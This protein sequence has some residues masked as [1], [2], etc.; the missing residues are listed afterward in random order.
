MHQIIFNRSRFDPFIDRST[1]LLRICQLAFA[2]G[3]LMLIGCNGEPAASPSPEQNGRPVRVIEAKALSG[4]ETFR[5]PAAL[6][7]SQRAHLAFLQPGYL[8]ERTVERGQDV[9]VGEVLATLHNPALQPGVAAAEAAVN[10][11]RSRLTQLEKDTARLEELVTRNLAS[12]DQLDQTRASRDGAQAALEQANARLDEAR[13]QLLDASLR[14]PFAGRIVEVM[15]EPGDFAAAGQPV[16]MIH[17]GNQLEIELQLPGR[18][19][20]RLEPG[21]SLD[22]MRFD[23]GALIGATVTE[24]GAAQPGQTATV[25]ARLKPDESLAWRPGDAV[26]AELDLPGVEALSVPLSSI[27][28]PGTRMSKIFRVRDQTAEEV[29]VE[30][31][32]T[33]RGWVQVNGS[34]EAGDP[35]VVAGQAQLLDGEP[36]RV[37][38]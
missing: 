6:R 37:I 11:A 8:A 38:D 36:V 28:N 3:V 30:T 1:S 23:D 12:Q 22:V 24:I 31:G 25:I 20:A 16:M 19:A 18:V 32:R 5:F 33:L 13:N 9:A 4:I 7:A 26:Y 29:L 15:L 21:Q 34:L 2:A 14:A 17:S 10:E 35:I 27:V